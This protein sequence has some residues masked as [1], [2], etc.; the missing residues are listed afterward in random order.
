M[1]LRLAKRLV[2]RSVQTRTA[3]AM[4]RL[5][6]SRSKGPQNSTQDNGLGC[7]KGKW[8]SRKRCDRGGTGKSIPQPTIRSSQTRLRGNA[9][10]IGY[11]CPQQTH[12]SSQLSDDL[13]E[14]GEIGFVQEGLCSSDR[15]QGRILAYTNPSEI[16]AIPLLRSG[17]ANFLLQS[18]PIW[19]KPG[20]S[21]V[22]KDDESCGGETNTKRCMYNY[23][24]RRLANYSAIP[25]RVQGNGEANTEN[26]QE[27]GTIIQLEK[28]Q[29]K[30][31]KFHRV[32]R[33]GL[34]HSEGERVSINRQS[35][36]VP[37]KGP[38][39]NLFRNF[40]AASV[41]EPHRLS[42]SRGRDSAART[43]SSEKA[44][45]RRSQSLQVLKSRQSGSLPRSSEEA[46]KVVDARSAERTGQVGRRPADT[47]P[48]HRRLRNGL[49][50]SVLRRASGS[51]SL[52]RSNEQETYQQQRP[53]SG[54]FGHKERKR[55]TRSTPTHSNRQYVNS[56]LHQQTRLFKVPLSS[57]AIREPVPSGPKAQ[58]P[59]ICSAP[60]RQN[61]Q[62]GRR[63]IQTID[64]VT[65]LDFEGFS[66]PGPDKSIWQPRDR[67]VRLP[68]KQQAPV[69]SNENRD[70]S[71]RRS[72]CSERGLEPMV[73]H[74]LVS[75][76]ERIYHAP[77]GES[78]ETVSGQSATGSATVESTALDTHTPTMVS[79]TSQVEGSSPRRDFGN[80][81]DEIIK[82]T[83]MEFLRHALRR[84]LPENIVE[85]IISPHRPSTSRQY[86]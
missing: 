30:S 32:V 29:A 74:L 40:L 63:T 49:G 1:A 51:R 48:G 80:G 20:S 15:P 39:S 85:D 26:W 84:N 13:D 34:G 10:G 27:D 31:H 53:E 19:S 9:A 45:H 38:Q 41:G 66:V 64:G 3:L 43:A 82:L 77:S 21:R 2:P 71:S 7:R 72:K 86:Q 56:L 75:T 67:L 47:D 76:P 12:C 62:L 60:S 50:L 23:V 16:Q 44:H 54:L 65:E 59:P 70:D 14:T 81:T 78:P 57:P 22:H 46:P 8:A 69:I 68:L 18:P 58:S 28:V 83:R 35:N 6:S 52:E 79:E 61:E 36:K 17:K 11:Q 73:S 42:E 37:E 24:L 25:P 4:A 5:S 55:S 33:S